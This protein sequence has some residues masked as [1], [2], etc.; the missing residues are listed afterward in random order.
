MSKKSTVLSFIAGASISG[1]I[2]W[3]YTRDYY[4]K[5]ADQEKNRQTGRLRSQDDLALPVYSLL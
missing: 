5:K 3:F 1:V 4:Y 2:T